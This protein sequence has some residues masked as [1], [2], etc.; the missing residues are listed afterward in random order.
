MRRISSRAALATL[1]RLV[2]ILCAISFGAFAGVEDAV[3]SLTGAR[4]RLVWVRDEG[5]VHAVYG[6]D[7][8]DGRGV[9]RVV[10]DVRT[11]AKPIFTQDG[12]R[13]VFTRRSENAVYIV[14]WDGTG[15]RK[16]VS[17][18]ASDVWRDPATGVDWL[19]VRDDD[20]GGTNPLVRYRLDDPSVVETFWRQTPLGHEQVPWFRL[21]HDGTRAADAFPWPRCGVATL[22][23][24]PTWR[25]YTNGCWPSIAPDDSYRMFVFNGDHR[26]V[27]MFD[28]DAQNRRTVRINDAPGIDGEEVYYPR[29]SNH[30]RFM[31]MTGPRIGKASGELYLG[32]F[33]E[34]FTAM[35][36]WVRITY[37]NTADMEGDAWIDPG[38]LGRHL[39]EAPYTVA[40]E[41]EGGAADWAWDFGDG[42]VSKGAV[43]RHTYSTPGRYTVVARG[44]GGERRGYVQVDAAAP[45]RPLYAV[46]RDGTEIVVKFD[47]DIEVR[48]PHFRMGSGA[49]VDGWR[50][51]T[52]GRTLVVTLDRR[53][54]DADDILLE[55]IA[56]R[57]QEPN[58]LEPQ[59]VTVRA[60]TWPV[61]GTEPIFVWKNANDP[62]EP[63]YRL[64]SR[65]EAAL[66]H[67]YAMTLTGG[68]FLADEADKHLLDAFRN[69]NALTVEATIAPRDLS[70]SGPARIVTFSTDSGSRNFTLGQQGDRLVFR[71][72][73]PRTGANGASPEVDLGPLTA[74]EPQHVVVTYSAG[75]LVYY[76][77]GKQVLE[78]HGVQGDFSN[79]EPHHFLFGDEWD[80]GRVWRGTLEGVALYARAL[81]PAE[82]QRSYEE[83]NSLLRAR[84]EVERIEVEATLV[85]RSDV[86][87]LGD[88]APYREALVMEEYAV[89]AVASGSL[90]AKRIRVARWAILGR[91]ELDLPSVGTAQP[92]RFKIESLAD[93][94]QLDSIYLSDTLDL[95]LDMPLFHAVR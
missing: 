18:F 48:R 15:L 63:T 5:G 28:A 58:R 41:S 40:L 2:A 22:T 42:A 76:R 26:T 80:G 30:P 34:G 9:R 61:D 83:H 56:D 65:D 36:G 77:N 45:P 87:A 25:E 8:E 13:V 46:V 79:W 23:G 73:T 85:D 17:G 47:E 20:G 32:R 74:R 59:W 72:R 16:L 93:N 4:T 68:A 95:D 43:G 54:A 19:Y 82:A 3:V 90:A 24:E 33:N 92:V 53:L 38:R 67:H 31:T 71:L 60:A 86:P 6:F 7:T 10:T 27:T 51:G 89:H 84:R 14:N 39:G 66:D 55:G 75:K 91:K 35:D 49:A 52:D 44:S 1:L 88:I 81:D 50:V 78:T 57:A 11:Y 37:D 69:A 12:S 29:W 62:G 70:Q 21:S 94:P 64:W